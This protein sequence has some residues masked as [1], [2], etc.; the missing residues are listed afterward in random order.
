M[1]ASLT[2]LIDLA[3]TTHTN[4]PETLGWIAELKV[5]LEALE[6]QLQTNLGPTHEELTKATRQRVE[7]K[8]ESLP[9]MGEMTQ[10]WLEVTNSFLGI[11]ARVPGRKMKRDWRVMFS[12]RRKIF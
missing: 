11:P 10:Q 12:R 1:E 6:V 5:L 8:L 3:F 4:D 9:N 2:A 7:K